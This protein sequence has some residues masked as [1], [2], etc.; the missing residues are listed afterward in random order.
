MV[1]LELELADIDYDALLRDY[2]PR[3]RDKLEQSGSP[4]AGMLSGGMAGTML[5]LAPTSLKDRLAAEMLNMNASKLEQQLTEMAA[6]NGINGKVQNL[7]ATV[8]SE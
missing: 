1:K 5:Q 3:I 6:R 8:V 4:L 2:L 7:K